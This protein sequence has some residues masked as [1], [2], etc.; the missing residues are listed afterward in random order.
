VSLPRAEDALLRVAIETIDVGVAAWDEATL[1]LVTGNALGLRLAGAIEPALLIEA[2][3]RL[4]REAVVT[5]AV[6]APGP[7]HLRVLLRRGR[8]GRGQSMLVA[9]I[10]QDE[11]AATMIDRLGFQNRERQVIELVMRGMRN[12]EIAEHLGVAEGTV[13]QYLN[14]IFGALEVRSRAELILRLKEWSH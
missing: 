9:S 1:A 2:R 3:E 8:L 10:Y 14:R 4:Q 7:S 12:R 5:L 6:L 13:K 11:D